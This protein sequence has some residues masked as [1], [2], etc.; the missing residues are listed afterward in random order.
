VITA[1]NARDALRQIRD[2]DLDLV[3]TD[4]KMPGM[5]GMGLL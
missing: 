2:G 3:I 5:N 1:D 4:M